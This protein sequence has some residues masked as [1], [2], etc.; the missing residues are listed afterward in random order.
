MKISGLNINNNAVAQNKVTEVKEFLNE[1]YTIRVNEFDPSKSEIKPK[2][3]KYDNPVTFDDI[4]LHLIE[5]GITVS[6]NILRKILRSPNQVQTFNPL[7]EYFESLKG[8]YRGVSHID[9]LMSHLRMREFP[10]KRKG[11]YQERMYRYM[12]KWFVA[13]AACALH[14]HPNDVAMGLIHQDE[15]IGKTFFFKFLVPEKLRNL[16]ADPKEDGKWNMEES[17]AR[18][19]LVYFDE[20]FGITRRNTEEFKKVLSASEID[21]YLPREPYP[22]RRNRIGSACFTSNKIPEKG[23]FLTSQMGYRRWLI[24]E[25]DTID[26]DYSKK[27]DVDQIWAEA[28]LL[29]DQ[30]FDYLWNMTD[31]NEFREHNKRYME[32]TTS[33][34]YVKMYFDIPQ[35]GEGSWLQPR[36]ILNMLVATRKVPRE[37]QHKIS[38]VK[39]GEALTA[40]SY[41]RKSIRRQD[42]VRSCYYV[43]PLL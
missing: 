11:Y 28:L 23:G 14:V 39:I 3:K 37:D 16:V 35:N 4:S 21:V 34:K 9:L 1:H 22:I 24:F 10:G 13:T 20:L 6:D 19:F 27:I 26:H 38:E 17:F 30:D 29:I 2:T 31:W 32:E 18:N 36:E 40:H 12:K 25:L 7:A 33:M 42:G 41:P 43:K 8:K 15:G 5:E